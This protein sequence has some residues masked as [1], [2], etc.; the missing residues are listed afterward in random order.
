MWPV[1]VIAEGVEEQEQLDRLRA[2]GCPFVQGY[3]YSRPLPAIEMKAL[4]LAGSHE[5][6]SH[7]IRGSLAG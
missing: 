1:S 3:Y 7:L 6:A 5:K 2:M 4:L